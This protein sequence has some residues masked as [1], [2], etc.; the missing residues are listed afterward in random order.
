M[1]DP[2]SLAASFLGIAS[3]GISMVT[4]LNTFTLSYTSA[5][6]KISSLP[7]LR[8]TLE[9]CWRFSNDFL[10]HHHQ[11]KARRKDTKAE[12]HRALIRDND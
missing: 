1:G 7:L 6:E 10:I 3:F 12:T 4:T 2:L 8:T 5:S 9:I 11:H